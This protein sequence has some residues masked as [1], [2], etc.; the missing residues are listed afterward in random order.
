MPPYESKATPPQDQIDLAVDLLVDNELP[1]EQRR[2]LLGR[3]DNV[4]GGWRSV[5]IRFLQRQVERDAARRLLSGQ[6]G[7]APMA[8]ARPRNRFQ[9]IVQSPSFRI[10]AVFILMAGAALTGMFLNHGGSHEQTVGAGR[11]ATA[12]TVL[13][14]LPRSITGGSNGTTSV[15][16][17]VLDPSLVPAGYPFSNG[18]GAD[19]S[20]RVIIVPDGQNRAV[21]FPVQEASYQ[22]GNGYE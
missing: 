4:P 18:S 21:A 15:N 11:P 19:A 12:S 17:P 10:A 13:A 14:T 3:L 1:E 7:R 22:A 16:V 2:S 5:G 20:Q 6:L 9:L 8:I